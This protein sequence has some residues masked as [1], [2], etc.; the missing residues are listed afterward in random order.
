MRKN[1]FSKSIY[2]SANYQI[3]LS[4]VAY[5]EVT[6][7]TQCNHFNEEECRKIADENQSLRWKRVGSWSGNPP[8]CFKYSS[9][10]VYFNTASWS[11]KYC[12][13]KDPC[14]CKPG[15]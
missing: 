8:G 2:L 6:S 14:I 7:G 10:G 3:Y 11:S 15:K 4:L 13:T 5:I 9:G 1:S 12:T